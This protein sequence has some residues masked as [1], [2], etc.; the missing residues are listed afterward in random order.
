MARIGTDQENVSVPIWF[1]GSFVAKDIMQWYCVDVA[2]EDVNKQKQF[3][4]SRSQIGEG[5][6]LSKLDEDQVQT[7][8]GKLHEK[9]PEI[10]QLLFPPG[11]LGL[12]IQPDS[13][14]YVVSDVACVSLGS[15]IYSIGA[16]AR[17]HDKYSQTYCLN[18]DLHYLDTN[19]LPSGWRTRKLLS[20]RELP[21]MA[22]LDDRIY[23]FGC[24]EREENSKVGIIDGEILDPQT[25]ETVIM[26]AK[27]IEYEDY[28]E[29]IT[30]LPEKKMIMFIA[31]ISLQIVYYDVEHKEWIH[32]KSHE[33]LEYKLRSMRNIFGRTTYTVVGTT[34]Y[35]FSYIFQVLAYD[36]VN[37]K[38]YESDCI[39]D[40]FKEHGT[41][42]KY[43]IN[44]MK[45]VHIKDD[46]F[47][48]VWLDAMLHC[49]KIDSE[50]VFD[51]HILITKLKICLD[52]ATGSISVSV[53]STHTY[54]VENFGV[55][56]NALFLNREK[57][58]M[59]GAYRSI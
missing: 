40:Y 19:D 32:E 10:V 26:P 12:R 37:E 25:G 47:C 5:D 53:L 15:S 55:L 43:R 3:R 27:T 4:L 39:A 54:L 44:F 6:K 7:K 8:K 34:I 29:L 22:V 52:K 18:Q 56:V 48:L 36:F 28:L 30:V 38:F 20:A 58:L 13:I 24:N 57:F 16:Y 42:L 35:W 49:R 51:K 41:I 14:D 21:Q 17:S 2:E 31:Q 59:K 45:L 1:C 23:I 33:V 11:K 50:E 9:E 46:Y